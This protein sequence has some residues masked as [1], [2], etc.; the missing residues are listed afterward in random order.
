MS[1]FASFAY[2]GR[3]TPPDQLELGLHAL[4]DAAPPRVVASR[5][6]QKHRQKN[7]VLRRVEY[8]RRYFPELDGET[9]SVGL[10]R[11][12]SGMAIPGGT[13]IWLNPA[14]LSYHTIAHELV[15][16]LQCRDLGIPSGEKACDVFSLARHWTLNDERPSYIKV[17]LALLDDRGRLSDA[18]ARV[19]F[20]VAR[21]AVVRRSQGMHRY[22]SFFEAELARRA[23]P[24]RIAPGGI[25][26]SVLG[27][28]S[29]R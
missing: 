23:E 2:S 19:V 12:A 17:P 7:D 5:V 26:A 25:T 13:R 4:P 8:V 20:E 9:I 28:F 27:V 16:L 21:E 22:L 1:D 10:T 29:R 15:H 18:Q 6:M 3:V 14:R 24:V 11:A